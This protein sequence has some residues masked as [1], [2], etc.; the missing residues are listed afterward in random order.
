MSLEFA[1]NEGI[2]SFMTGAYL[3]PIHALGKHPIRF[4]KEQRDEFVK[5]FY[6]AYKTIFG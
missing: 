5:G 2:N 4:N 1:F 6:H 3:T